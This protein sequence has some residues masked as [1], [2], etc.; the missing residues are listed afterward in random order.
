MGSCPGAA[1]DHYGGRQ[2][3]L[4]PGPPPPGAGGLC[5]ASAFTVCLRAPT[6]C[7]GVHRGLGVEQDLSE[8]R[9][10]PPPRSLHTRTGGGA[11]GGL[12]KSEAE[13]G[14]DD[15]RHH[16]RRG[17]CQPGAV[18]AEAAA[19]VSAG[20][21]SPGNGSHGGRRADKSQTEQGGDPGVVTA[22]AT[23]M[24]GL[25]ERGQSWGYSGEG[26]AAPSVRAAQELTGGVCCWDSR[27]TLGG[28]WRLEPPAALGVETVQVPGDSD[29]ASQR[30]GRSGLPLLPAASLPHRS[31][32]V[33]G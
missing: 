13:R 2:A 18:E 5:L 30:A 9:L 17:R 10:P 1:A 14:Q 8:G 11:R 25:G 23:A 15:G 20:G 27:A 28:G 31:P 22:R 19:G 4:P 3:P 7:Q 12:C 16:L 33:M 6:M 26:G 32:P 24:L 21:R 29:R